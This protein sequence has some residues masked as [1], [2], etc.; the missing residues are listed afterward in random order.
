MPRA[1]LKTHQTVWT[2]FEGLPV[3]MAFAAVIGA[4]MITAPESF[5]GYRMYT[6]LASTVVPRSF[7]ASVSPSSSPPERSTSPS[8]PF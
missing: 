2:R 3:I 6:T 4:F 8:L 5:L 7:S 1:E